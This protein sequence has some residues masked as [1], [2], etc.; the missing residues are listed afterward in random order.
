MHEA[1]TDLSDL[2]PDLPLEIRY[3]TPHNLTG[4]PLAGYYAARALLATPAALAFQKAVE[5]FRKLG[6]DV[7]VYDAYRPA[8]AVDDFLR[9]SKQPEDG[10]TKDEFY[11]GLEKDRLFGMGYIAHRS[12]HSRGSA[13]DLTLTKDGVPLDMGSCFDFMDEISWQNAPGLTKEQEE[14]RA[15]LRGVMCWAG[16]DPL[17]TEW[18]HFRYMN[19][20]FP[21]TYFDFVIE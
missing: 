8:C 13:I 20:P 1:F 15:I 7:L 21:D 19:E 12:G 11:P 4:H 2:I 17:S 16:F 10:L 14:N 9:W 6:Y 5:Q 3:A 18:W